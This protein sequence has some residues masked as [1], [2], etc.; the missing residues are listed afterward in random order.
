M[1]PTP[2]ARSPEQA[3]R[4]VRQSSVRAAAD[5]ADGRL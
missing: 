1:A 2:P 4:I 3:M 5:T